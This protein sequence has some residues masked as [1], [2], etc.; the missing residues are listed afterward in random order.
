MVATLAMATLT[1]A[2][3]FLTAGRG[4]TPFTLVVPK[5]FSGPVWI[6]LDPAGQNIPLGLRG[7]RAVVPANGVLRVRS[8]EP[9]KVWHEIHDRFSATFDDGS[10]LPMREALPGE[11]GL[12]GGGTVTTTKRDGTPMGWMPFFVGTEEQYRE[13]SEPH[14]IDWPPET[15]R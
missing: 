14:G 9:A 7:Y 15:D 6:V 12:R 2:L 1:V 11:V 13:N 5:G 8:L 10:P 3:V 4:F